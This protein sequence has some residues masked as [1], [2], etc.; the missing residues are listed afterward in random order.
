VPLGVVLAA[1]VV[2]LAAGYLIKLPCLTGDW[3]DGR[4]YNR[5]CYSD[6]AALYAA[7][8]RD[9]GL[10]EDRVPYLS[11]ENEYPVLSG[12]AMWAAALP[13]RS[14]VSFFNWTALVLTG[15]ALVTG[16]ALHRMA[17]A[18]ALFFG[19]APSL[20]LYGFVNWD[21]IAVGLATLGTLAFLRGRDASAGALLGLGA[22][23]KLYPGLLVVPFALDR[24]WRRWIPLVG[25]AVG[26][27]LAV[28]LPFA[29]LAPERWA[30]FF[31]F[32]AARPPDFD[33]PWYIAAY[34][35]GFQWGVGVVNTLSFVSF[36]A[37]F[38][39]I[40]AVAFRRRPDLPRWTLGFPLLVAF[41]LTN[42]VFSPQFGLWLLP[43]FAL[44]LPH[45]R[46]FVAF[47]VAQVLVFVTRFQYFARLVEVGPGLPF[48][49]LEVAVLLRAAI[50]VACVIA[51]TR[52][53]AAPP[54]RAPE[55][56]LEAA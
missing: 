1:V 42:K 26:T 5:L 44:T 37:V 21:L 16:W 40:A 20:A 3:R 31:R 8:D 2:S 27:W 54:A 51:W 4:Q 48:W 17:G 49:S 30:E 22:A 45:P 29:A 36:V 55:P 13:A 46:L 33:S 39:V 15:F 9:R 56:A 18:N 50:L 14:H 12:L 23:A 24:G 10:V 41:L 6:V 7:E 32:S 34:H 11:G 25:V 19:L 28:N 35:L 38:A 52:Q 53:G 43:W 47:E